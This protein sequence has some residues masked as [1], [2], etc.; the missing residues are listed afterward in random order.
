V[1][2]RENARLAAVIQHAIV[3]DAVEGAAQA[4][5]YLAAQS[6]PQDTILRVLSGDARR[7]SDVRLAMHAQAA[8]QK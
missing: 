3:I 6:F 4:W 5:A 1:R 8:S 2:P 7:A